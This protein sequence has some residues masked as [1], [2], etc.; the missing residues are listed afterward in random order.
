[1]RAVPADQPDHD[2]LKRPTSP[3]VLLTRFLRT[4]SLLAI[5]VAASPKYFSE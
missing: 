5:V 4:E 3:K 1:M 2:G